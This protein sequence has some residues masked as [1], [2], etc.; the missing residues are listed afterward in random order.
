[1]VEFLIL[2][3]VFFYFY[4]AFYRSIFSFYILFELFWIKHSM[5]CL[6]TFI[7]NSRFIFYLMRIQCLPLRRDSVE[8]PIRS[9]HQQGLKSFTEVLK[10]RH[11]NTPPFFALYVLVY[12]RI[13]VYQLLDKMLIFENIYNLN[14]VQ[15]LSIFFCSC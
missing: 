9:R 7:S 13:L 10:F 15:F 12:P 11:N 4:F 2:I 5:F 1:M 6:E 3:L 14:K 8:L